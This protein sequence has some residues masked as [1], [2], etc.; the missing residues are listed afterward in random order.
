MAR[1]MK[2]FLC[3][4]CTLFVV[5]CSWACAHTPNSAEYEETA[6]PT[7]NTYVPYEGDVTGANWRNSSD[8]GRF[9]YVVYD[10]RGNEF[11]RSE[12]GSPDFTEVGKN[13]LRADL[14]GGTGVRLSRFFEIEKG[15]YSSEY[16]NVLAL[17]YGQVAYAKWN[18]TSELVLELIAHDIFDAELNRSVFQLDFW[19]EGFFS[20][21]EE[22]QERSIW[23]LPILAL[24]FIS[25]NQ[26]FIEYWNV[27]SELVEKYLELR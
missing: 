14:P 15:L 18:D 19:S 12:F 2:L 10:N 17:D 25:E 11:Y 27:N 4:L 5:A 6:T 16:S 13:L 26:L 1:K 7:Q 23:M 20:M 3:F 24:N 22:I 9:Y 21:P 8:E